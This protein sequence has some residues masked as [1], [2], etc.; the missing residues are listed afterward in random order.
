METLNS[1]MK[2]IDPT[3]PSSSIKLVSNSAMNIRSTL[4]VPSTF[5]HHLVSPY[6]PNKLNK[7]LNNL[8]MENSLIGRFHEKV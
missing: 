3:A 8:K 1:Q 4:S 6:S 7:K 2:T 5:N